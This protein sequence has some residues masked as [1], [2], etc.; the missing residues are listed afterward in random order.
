MTKHPFNLRRWQHWLATGLGSGLAPVAPGTVG[1]LAA[2]PLVFALAQLPTLWSA[3]FI[4]L[5]VLLGIYVS[6]VVSRDLGVDDHGGIVID[7]VAGFAITM[8]AL[9]FDWAWLLAGFCLFRLLDI[10]KP[11]P[12]RLFDQ[13][14]SGG[15]GVMADD[16]VAGLLACCLLHGVSLAL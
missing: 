2:V 15:L 1:T 11:W 16:I 8:W 12:V 13:H 9:P 7:E 4:M 14:V 10:V 5:L 3:G 6:E